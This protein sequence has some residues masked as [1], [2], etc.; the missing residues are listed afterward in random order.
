MSPQTRFRL[1]I[2][3]IDGAERY[4]GRFNEATGFDSEAEVTE[5]RMSHPTGLTHIIQLPAGA[6][7][8]GAVTLARPISS[9]RGLWAWWSLAGYEHAHLRPDCTLDVLDQGGTTIARFSLT[10]AL[11]PESQGIPANPDASP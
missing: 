2:V 1:R 10:P 3:E 11:L 4:V 5:Q 7:R 6:R 9:D 8:Y